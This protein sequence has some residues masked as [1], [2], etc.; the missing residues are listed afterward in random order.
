MTIFFSFG[1]SETRSPCCP[2]AV[3]VA[4]PVFYFHNHTVTTLSVKP[5]FS[6]IS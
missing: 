3:E 4:T 6:S 2:V 1:K 5:N